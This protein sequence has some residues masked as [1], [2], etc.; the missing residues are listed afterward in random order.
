[1]KLGEQ[2]K[3]NL[4]WIIMLVVLGITTLAT[5][6]FSISFGVENSQLKEQ[7]AELNIINKGLEDSN[8]QLN[9]VNKELNDSKNQADKDIE[10]LN[11][12]VNDLQGIVDE[13]SEF[14]SIVVL[15]VNGEK[16]KT[17]IVK[18]NELV[19]LPILEDTETAYFNGWKLSGVNE[20]YPGE[21]VYT[22]T[23]PVKFVAEFINKAVVNFVIDSEVTDIQYVKHG[24][25]ITLPTQADTD[26]K[27]YNGWKVNGVG[28]SYKNNYTV[29][30]DMNFVLDMANKAVVNFVNG[31]VVETEYVKHGESITLPT[32]EDTDKQYFTGW[33]IDGA[34]ELYE[35]ESTYIITVDIKFV[36]NIVKIDVVAT[37][38]TG[39]ESFSGN[40]IWADGENTYYSNGTDQYVLNGNE[41]T[42]VE[43]TGL[44]TFYGNNVWT[45]G[46]SIYYSFGSEQQYVLD[47]NIWKVKDWAGFTD[48]YGNKIWTDGEKFYYSSFNYSPYIN[49]QYVLNGNEWTTIEWTGL[50][51]GL[52]CDDIWSDGE[53]IYY[54]VA[55]EQYV[56]GENNTWVHS[57]FSGGNFN[58]SGIWTDGK[59]IYNSS[60]SVLNGDGFDSKNWTG[61]TDFTG[62]NIW[63]DG[64]KFYYSYNDKQYV[65]QN[66]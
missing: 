42:P 14:A 48:F 32:V 40:N 55:S 44:P 4:V 24:E 28:E 49:L 3:K 13:Y 15:E 34:G 33:L 51:G 10:D 26:T 9:D 7:N 50:M 17:E 38:F 66:L 21:Y 36:A 41:W 59:N 25:L 12:A 58:G 35:A 47:G 6:I 11:D 45:D 61:F 20:P 56:L 57:K 62:D 52:N 5:G 18:N 46:E 39:L 16:Y 1:M 2:M 37:E 30:A 43:W 22:V 60:H 29:D 27:Y 65:F 19:T 63:T 53:N 54:S 64:E 23:K 8:K 31:N